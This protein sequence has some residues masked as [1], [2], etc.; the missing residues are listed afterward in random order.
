MTSNH[1]RALLFWL[2]TSLFNP[3]APTYWAVSRDLAWAGEAKRAVASSPIGSADLLWPRLDVKFKKC[4]HTGS[5]CRSLGGGGGGM[6]PLNAS[7]TQCAEC[8][9]SMSCTWVFHV[10][11]VCLCVFH[12]IVSV[13]F[14]H[15][16]QSLWHSLCPHCVLCISTSICVSSCLSCSMFTVLC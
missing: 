5:E 3:I 13:S 9:Y 6:S 10:L 4:Q 8:S 11:L 14:T 2:W 16:P 12:N 15:S 7:C 1:T